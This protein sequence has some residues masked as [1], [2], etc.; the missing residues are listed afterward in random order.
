VII[1]STPGHPSS[2]PKNSFERFSMYV[3]EECENHFSWAHLIESNEEVWA[4]LFPT[5]LKRARRK[6][7]TISCGLLYKK[8]FGK[9]I[10]VISSLKSKISG[11]YFFDHIG[12]HYFFSKLSNQH[13]FYNGVL[14]F[15]HTSSH[16][17]KKF[18]PKGDVDPLRSKLSPRSE[19]SPIR[20]SQGLNTHPFVH[21]KG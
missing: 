1:T 16:S 2:H 5:A 12:F 9:F 11:C 13:H 3:L 4:E 10:C 19:H 21:P 18:V 17:G 8:A 7:A 15:Y 6:M 14:S 20:S